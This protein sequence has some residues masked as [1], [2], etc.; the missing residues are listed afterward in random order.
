M[1][2][3]DIELI[4]ESHSNAFLKAQ[5]SIF[6]DEEIVNSYDLWL[7]YS[8]WRENSRVYSE[9]IQVN[10][11]LYLI[12]Y[13]ESF[14]PGGGNSGRINN[15][16]DQNEI[17]VDDNNE[18]PQNSV[19]SQSNF[20][21]DNV[22]VQKQRGFRLQIKKMVFRKHCST[23]LDL[24]ML[25]ESTVTAENKLIDD[26]WKDFMQNYKLMDSLIN[27]SM[28]SSFFTQLINKANMMLT[29]EEDEQIESKYI[30]PPIK[31]EKEQFKEEQISLYKVSSKNI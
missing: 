20:M 8:N 13:Y 19:I 12:V 30:D 9:I 3:K 1:T 28:G 4:I 15:S 29:D 5:I 22:K 14:A 2:D 16:K 23:I 18:N 24:M 27:I 6:E 11:N 10:V 26:T 17:L 31:T 21:N 7:S 25:D